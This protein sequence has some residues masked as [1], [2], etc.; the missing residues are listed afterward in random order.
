MYYFEIH[1]KD[2]DVP[3]SNWIHLWNLQDVKTTLTLIIFLLIT[4]RWEANSCCY[5]DDDGMLYRGHCKGEAFGPTYT[6]ED[7][8]GAEI[9]NGQVVGSIYKDMKGP[10][11][12][13]IVVHSQNEEYVTCTAIAFLFECPQQCFHCIWILSFIANTSY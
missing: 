8:V 2:A 9:K 4:I 3:D 12:P 5:H 7:V 6:S 1:V 10:L 11:F 13:T